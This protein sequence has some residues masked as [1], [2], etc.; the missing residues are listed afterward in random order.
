MNQRLETE[1]GH[2]YAELRKSEK[3]VADYLLGGQENMKELTLER[4]AKETGVSQP[5]VLR[6][7]KALGYEGFKDFKYELAGSEQEGGD[8]FLYGYKLSDGDPIREV[9]AKIVGT[10]MGQ[11]GETVKSIEPEILELVVRTIAQ[12]NRIAVYYVE[13]SSCTAQDLVTKLVYLGLHC[14]S[15]GDAYMQ[16]VSA[17]SLTKEDVAIGISYSGYSRLTVDAMEI[18]RRAGAKTIAITNFEHTLIAR[19]SDLV[20]RTSNRQ[21]LYGDAIFSRASQLL[22]VDMIY[23]GI[24]LS[25]YKKYTKRLDESSRLIQKQAYG[26]EA[27]QQ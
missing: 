22:V 5:T 16:S 26:P 12:A 24:L 1:I 20:L 8:K 9:P 23:V 13:N 3:K 11:I 15:Y 4:L 21:F 10:A 6:F 27:E 7:V 17:A 19:H 25:D 18:A 14:F 2:V